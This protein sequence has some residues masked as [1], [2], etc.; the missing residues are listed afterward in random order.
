MRNSVFKV[1]G[2]TMTL[3]LIV[4]FAAPQSRRKQESNQKSNSQRS[5][6]SQRGNDNNRRRNDTSTTRS[7]PGVPD[8]SSGAGQRRDTSNRRENVPPTTRQNR[9]NSET[10]RTQRDNSS[11]TR[12]LPGV[13]DRRN[14]SRRTDTTIGGIGTR[15]QRD[16]TNVDRNRNND[17]IGRIKNDRQRGDNQTGGLGRG[18]TTDRN[19]NN[20]SVGRINNDRQRGDN[21]TGGLGRGTATD[22]NRGNNGKGQKSD[23]IR[24]LP[25]VPTDGRKHAPIRTRS[26]QTHYNSDNN[27]GDRTRIS[28]GIRITRPG[29][30]NMGIQRRLSD[31]EKARLILGNGYRNGYYH[32][33]RGWRDDYFCYP[34]YVF[35]P[36]SFNRF[37]CSPWYYYSSLPPYL[38]YDRVIIVNGGYPSYGWR[39]NPYRWNRPVY[40]VSFTW[41]NRY[42]SQTQNQYS[43]L[44]Y[45]LDDLARSFEQQDYDA[46][47]L[48]C[49]KDGKVNMYFDGKYGYSLESND[50]YD[51]FADGIE[52][53]RTVRYDISNIRYNGNNSAKVTAVHEFTDP[54]GKRGVTYHDYFLVREG[55]HWVIREFG[56]SNAP[57]NW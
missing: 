35:N 3:A 8:R 46:M 54:F 2:V 48:L 24:P 7:F 23:P 32:Y 51:L 4:A 18:T 28:G 1:I 33:N 11:P 40:S 10:T 13:P 21:Q 47:D 42:Q 36:W 14:D 15:R 12:G 31:A 30:I 50:F 25:G 52:N 55:S 19:R 49:P 38:S 27:I 26:G 22:R 20:D 17:S 6:S 39:G 43:D 56:T 44:D 34:H 37:V 16:N 57:T 45:A 41:S 53:V 9:G 29:S 5:E